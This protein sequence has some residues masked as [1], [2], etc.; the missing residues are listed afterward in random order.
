MDDPEPAF[1]RFRGVQKLV[2]VVRESRGWLW[3]P[4]ISTAQNEKL[5]SLRTLKALKHLD[6]SQNFQ[7][8]DECLKSFLPPLT[9]LAQ[10]DLSGCSL[11]TDEGLNKSLSS[12]TG[13]GP[14]A[15]VA[16]GLLDDSYSAGLKCMSSV[17]GRGA[18]IASPPRGS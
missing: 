6:L 9:T 10:L 5:Q 16:A 14:R 2:M 15:A 8:T 12:L 3:K 13:D 17:D 18:A 7:L 11:L 1:Q 4:R